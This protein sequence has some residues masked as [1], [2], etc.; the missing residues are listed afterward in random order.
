MRKLRLLHLVNTV[1]LGGLEI[2]VLELARRLKREGIDVIIA[3]F[4][5][6]KLKEDFDSIGIPVVTIPKR[7]GFDR[8]VIGAIRKLCKQKKI[9]IIHSHNY[10]PWV[11]SSLSKGINGDLKLVHTEHAIDLSTHGIRKRIIEFLLSLATNQIIADSNFIAN[12]LIKSELIRKNKVSVIY[13]GVDHV[14]FTPR[15]EESPAADKIIFTIVARLVTI[16]NHF[17]LIDAF[18]KLVQQQKFAAELW[19]VGDGPLMDDLVA[20]AKEIGSGDNIVF[21]GQRDDI[22]NILSQSDVFVLPSN[23]EGLSVSLLEAAASGLPIIASDVGGSSDIVVNGKTGYLFRKNDCNQLVYLMEKLAKNPKL[24]RKLG[25]NGRERIERLFT[26]DKMLE[27]YLAVYY[28][29]V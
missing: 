1:D 26:F 24:R 4:Q 17:L 8:N 28:S 2:L 15:T 9:N 14:Q 7:D 13:N 29:V 18:G 19:I 5:D 3:T 23:S 20:R 22:P 10:T 27:R 16:K 11:Y 25:K 12:F 21:W 6:G